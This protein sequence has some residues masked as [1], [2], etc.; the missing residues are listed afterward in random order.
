[1]TDHKGYV[2]KAAGKAKLFLIRCPK[3]GR[4]NYAAA[5]STGVCVWCEYVAKPEDVRKR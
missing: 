5:V 4:E 3:C 2:W 1:M